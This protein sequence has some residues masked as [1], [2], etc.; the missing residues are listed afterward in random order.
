MEI[1]SDYPPI[2]E[3][4][5]ARGDFGLPEL[6]ELGGDGE[7]QQNGLANMDTST[8]DMIFIQPFRGEAQKE[9]AVAVSVIGTL[10]ACKQAMPA[11]AANVQQAIYS[12]EDKDLAYF[13][14]NRLTDAA[15]TAKALHVDR[16]VKEFVPMDHTMT[17]T[18]KDGPLSQVLGAFS[19]AACGGPVGVSLYFPAKKTALVI[20][21][22]E[23]NEL[24]L[25]DPHDDPSAEAADSLQLGG[26]G[27]VFRYNIGFF[28][29][30]DYVQQHYQNVEFVADFFVPR[31][32]EP[33]AVAVATVAK[34][35]SPPPPGIEKLTIQCEAAEEPSEEGKRKRSQQPP[36]VGSPMRMES[37][38]SEEKRS[39]SPG[40]KVE[41]KPAAARKASVVSK[42]AAVA[43]KAVV[44]K[45]SAA[46]KAET[47]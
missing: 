6:P 47:K 14:V 42:P 23:N 7:E 15:T 34:E 11:A 31:A 29:M 5:I 24:T 33:A 21:G 9:L 2:T 12:C 4:E 3:E 27:A 32:E 22:S 45:A 36:A 19:M 25:I 16:V 1:L 18:S 8:D 41:A 28:D 20:I 26:R 30:Q 37:E 13:D 46:A 43:K 39:K 10:F 44:P 38:E 35:S 40:A 17:F